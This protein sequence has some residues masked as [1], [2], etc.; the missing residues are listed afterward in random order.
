VN[1]SG[2]P[3]SSKIAKIESWNNGTKFEGFTDGT[4]VVRIEVQD[5]SGKTKL[6]LRK[7]NNQG[8]YTETIGDMK[9]P[10]SDYSAPVLTVLGEYKTRYNLGDNVTLYPATAF[11]VLKANANLTLTVKKPNGE[12]Y[13][14]GSAEAEK[15]L[16]LTEYGD[17][18]ITYS[19]H[20]GNDWFATEEQ[21][22]LRAVDNIPPIIT[23]EISLP[24][25]LELN[26]EYVF[27]MADVFDNVTQECKYYV[28]V[29][30]PDAMREAVVDN[31]YTF[32]SKGMYIVTYYAVDDYVNIAQ[33]TF[34]IWVE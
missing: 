22:I 28:I 10:F 12:L 30:R 8:F 16:L 24:K 4:M 29:S 13:Y 18:I 23:G 31:K 5:V 6:S 19:T 17:W 21:Y 3:L 32:T 14:K 9:Q 11:D 2:N 20:D 26:T 25:Q 33:M 15:K 1:T 27:P 7:V 34:S